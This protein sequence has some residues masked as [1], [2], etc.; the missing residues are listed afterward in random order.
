M[1]RIAADLTMLFR[2][3]PFLERF[4]R[5]AEAGFTGVEFSLEPGTEPAVIDEAVRRAGVEVA[6]VGLVADG[7]SERLGSGAGRDRLLADIDRVVRAASLLEPGTI[8]LPTGISSAVDVPRPLLVSDIAEAARRLGDLGVGLVVGPP[9]VGGRRDAAIGTVGE[10]VEV[11]DA[12]GRPDVGLGYDLYRSLLAGENPFTVLT[13]HGPRI[14]HVRVADVP[15]GHEPGTGRFDFDLF[16]DKLDEAGYAGWVGL[17]YRPS[18]DTAS[19]LRYVRERGLL[20]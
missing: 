15:G 18:S 4:D 20:G 10:G 16:F 5:A 19:S 14:D 12:V 7:G 2:E 6:H 11:L 3:H 8:G 1:P 17:G 9:G 13:L